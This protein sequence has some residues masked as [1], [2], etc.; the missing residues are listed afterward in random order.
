MCT[1]AVAWLCVALGTA[2]KSVETASN[3]PMFL[4]LLPFLGSG[5]V[6]TDSMPTALRWFAEYQP[7][8]PVIE[9][10]RGLLLGTPIG[11]NALIAVAWC[12]AIGSA[13]YLWARALY[14]RKSVAVPGR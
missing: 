11:W 2:A 4:M 13:G 6:H 10:L 14:D 9:T 5:F 1:L 3:T 7:F 12:T 8:T